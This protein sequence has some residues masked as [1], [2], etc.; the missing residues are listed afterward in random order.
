MHPT[1]G[2]RGEDAVQDKSGSGHE[3]WDEMFSQT[4]FG[5]GRVM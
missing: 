3:A 1:R 5:V 4:G 2:L